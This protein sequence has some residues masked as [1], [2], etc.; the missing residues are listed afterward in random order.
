MARDRKRVKVVMLAELERVPTRS[1]F[2][3][4]FFPELVSRLIDIVT[5]SGAIG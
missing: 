3:Y 4:I 2:R 5:P 1:L